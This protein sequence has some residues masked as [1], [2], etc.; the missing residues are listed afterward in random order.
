[1]ET[2]DTMTKRTHT[3]MLLVAALLH[4]ACAPDLGETLDDGDSSGSGD[5]GDSGATTGGGAM[6]GG[7]Q[8]QHEDEGNGVTRTVVDATSEEQ[9]IHL[10]LESRLQLELADPRESDAWDLGFRRFAIAIDGG[11]SGPGGMEAVALDG[12][13][14]DDVTEAPADGWVTDAADG[15]DED[16]DP[17]LA[18]AGWYAYDFMTHVL[19]PQPLVYVVRTVEGN[20]FKLEILDYYDEAGTGGTLTIRWAPLAAE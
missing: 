7:P 20:A 10:D 14:F 18:F 11:I 13:A 8:V 15:D 16:E 17:D 3:M 19:T 5:S 2:M 6:D 4:A 9:W 12:V 1:M